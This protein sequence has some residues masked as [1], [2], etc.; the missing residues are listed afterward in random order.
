V[1]GLNNQ[2]R[3]L[4]ERAGQNHYREPAQNRSGANGKLPPTQTLNNPWPNAATRK[5]IGNITMN[6]NTSPRANNRSRRE[7][8]YLAE[9]DDDFSSSA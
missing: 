6:S 4:G 3:H 1:R 2:Y 8:E 7:R 5:L 9:C